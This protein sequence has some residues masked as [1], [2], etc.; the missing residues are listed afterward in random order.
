MALVLS[1][2][3][4][5]PTLLEQYFMSHAAI[6]IFFRCYGQSKQREWLITP[7]MLL[8]EVGH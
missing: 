8:T 7:S 4:F 2:F 3:I 5:K 6:E 1:A